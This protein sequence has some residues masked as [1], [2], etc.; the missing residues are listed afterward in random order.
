MV[1]IPPPRIVVLAGLP[2]SGKSTWAAGQPGTALSSDEIRR[3]LTD[4]VTN[5]QVH[6]RVFRILRQLLVQRLELRRPVTYIDAT[7]LTPWERRPYLELAQLYDAR[8]EA[9]YFATPLGVCQER[10]R[11]RDRV[12]PDEVLAEMARKLTPPAVE[13]GFCSVTVIGA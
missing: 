5:Q 7:N 4:D 1:E 9:V 3:L 12:V 10:N 13:E 6:R 11:G 8:A 2:G